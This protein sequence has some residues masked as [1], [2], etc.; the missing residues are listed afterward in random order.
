M[1]TPDIFGIES[2]K[3]VNASTGIHCRIHCWCHGQ[4]IS[5]KDAW[6][7]PARVLSARPFEYIYS[8]VARHPTPAWEPV[9]SEQWHPP[10]SG[11]AS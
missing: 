11:P 6:Y 2:A 9:S 1:R 8:Q 5:L 7:F 10:S 3:P 4:A